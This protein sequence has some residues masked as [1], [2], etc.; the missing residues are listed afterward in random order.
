MVHSIF[1]PTSAKADMP[2]PSP[3][4]AAVISTSD[5]SAPH[6]KGGKCEPWDGAETLQTVAAPWGG[7][8]AVRAFGSAGCRGVIMIHGAAQ[9]PFRKR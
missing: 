8:V 9:M 5:T 4:A 7:G 6:I 1:Y 2:P 3:P